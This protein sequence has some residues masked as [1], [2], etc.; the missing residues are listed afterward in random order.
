[1]ASELITVVSGLPRSGTSLMMQ[2]LRAGG[3]EVLAD[4]LRAADEHNPHGYFEDARVKHLREDA[5]WLGEARAKVVKI[6][7]PLLGALPRGH[8]YRV[9]W[10][11]RDLDE[12]LASQRH[13]LARQS[14]APPTAAAD[15]ALRAAFRDQATSLRSE[16]G[17]RRIPVCPIEHRLAIEDPQAVAERL[18]R[19]LG[20]RFDALAAASAVDPSLYRQ[21]AG[22]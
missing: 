13:M 8:A 21:R 1:V 3:M 19:F 7:T 20:T 10:M 14:G 22:A 6:V 4:P 2:M 17:R 9:I 16:L 11:E 15:H 18:Q 5:S 12:V